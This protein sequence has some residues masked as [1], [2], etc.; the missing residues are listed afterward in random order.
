MRKFLIALGLI[1]SAPLALGVYTIGGKQVILN[2]S[3]S[4]IS[5]TAE[6]QID[7]GAATAVHT[8]YTQDGTTGTTSTDGLR[9]WIT[10]LR[11]QKFGIMR[12]RRFVLEQTI[13]KQ[14]AL[15][16]DKMLE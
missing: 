5:P 3:S 15:Q 2:P 6:Q 4:A 11:L 16:M 10:L 1:L 12:I 9:Y 14:C 7:W 8:K 13:Q